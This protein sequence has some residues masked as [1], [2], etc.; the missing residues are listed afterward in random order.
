MNQ[1]P[2]FW[3]SIKSVYKEYRWQLLHVGMDEYHWRTI[4]FRVPFG[5]LFYR[6]KFDYKC[7]DECENE[8]VW[9]R[10]EG[11]TPEEEA[12]LDAFWDRLVSD[13]PSEGNKP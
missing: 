1:R 2:F 3:W 6:W 13:T 4:G 11:P 10:P 9:G 12:E 5:V 7:W 8:R